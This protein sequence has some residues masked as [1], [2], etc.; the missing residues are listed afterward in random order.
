MTVEKQS[1]LY[2]Q[3][4]WPEVGMTSDDNIKEDIRLG[5]MASNPNAG[6]WFIA[7]AQAK[8]DMAAY[9]GRRCIRGT[10]GRYFFIL[11]A[12]GIDHVTLVDAVKETVDTFD[13]IPW[14]PINLANE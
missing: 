11:N 4:H 9:Q 5:I 10:G 1:T 6:A 12:P 13:V 2:D 3:I 14:T 7:H 8:V